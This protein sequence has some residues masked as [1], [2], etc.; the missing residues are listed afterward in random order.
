MVVSAPGKQPTAANTT[1]FI[2]AANSSTASG[3][4]DSS[5]AARAAAGKII[6]S[7]FAAWSMPAKYSVRA[8]A[9]VSVSRAMSELSA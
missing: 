3:R 8:I 6:C 5:A 1:M 4:G 7:P 2:A 9:V